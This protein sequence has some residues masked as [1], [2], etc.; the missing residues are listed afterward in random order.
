M[1]V[2]PRSQDQL[3][4]WQ[5]WN[6]NQDLLLSTSSSKTEKKKSSRTCHSPCVS[7][8]KGFTH[9][10][11]RER[12]LQRAGQHHPCPHPTAGPAPLPSLL[13]TTSVPSPHVLNPLQGV[14]LRQ[15]RPRQLPHPSIQERLLLR[16][17]LRCDHT[18]VPSAMAS[19]PF[20]E[21]HNHLTSEKPHLHPAHLPHLRATSTP[22]FVYGFADS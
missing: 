20:P 1:K 16:P 9:R 3:R 17:L 6:G 15:L 8:N 11:P 13:W 10:R 21:S 19:G 5:I 2:S 7:V 4:L 18:P 14:S 12:C 22:L